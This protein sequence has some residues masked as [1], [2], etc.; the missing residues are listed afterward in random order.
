M[1]FAELDETV[2]KLANRFVESPQIAL[3]K[4]KMGLNQNLHSAL[5]EA[6][7]FEAVGQDECFHSADFIEGVTAF[8]QKRKAV[9]NQSSRNAKA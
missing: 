3:E 8:M 7:E 9:F 4:I 5:A 2:E 1:P 6:L